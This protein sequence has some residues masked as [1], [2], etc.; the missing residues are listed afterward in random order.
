[1]IEEFTKYWCVMVDTNISREL[2]MRLAKDCMIASGMCI[3]CKHAVKVTGFRRVEKP[4][5]AC[6]EKVECTSCD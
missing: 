3:F 6:V 5:M 4:D 1:M 2:K